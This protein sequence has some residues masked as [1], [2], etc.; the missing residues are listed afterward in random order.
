MELSTAPGTTLR[1]TKVYQ[2]DLSR[3]GFEGHI[4][5]GFSLSLDGANSEQRN[6]TNLVVSVKFPLKNVLDSPRIVSMYP[7]KPLINWIK[8]PERKREDDT[9]AYPKDFNDGFGI[10]RTKWNSAGLDTNVA[11]WSL[12][13]EHLTDPSCFSL[14]VTVPPGN[15]D[16]SIE[17]RARVSTENNLVSF[18]G[19]S[20][21]EATLVLPPND[22]WNSDWTDPGSHTSW[23][24]AQDVEP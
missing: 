12:K 18:L 8:K 10:Y 6:I 7:F 4:A 1:I 2:Q 14:V 11:K 3:V 21:G 17:V 9:I 24:T 15:G 13:G 5:L 23:L 20:V 19:R 22:C 16:F